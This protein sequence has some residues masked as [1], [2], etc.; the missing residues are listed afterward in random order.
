MMEVLA[1]SGP[2]ATVPP[3]RGAPLNGVGLH[4]G[5]PPWPVFPMTC[6]YAYFEYRDADLQQDVVPID[7]YAEYWSV[8]NQDKAAEYRRAH[9]ALVNAPLI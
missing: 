4:R 1:H 5:R 3:G 2:L 7:T 9:D 8:A 6:M